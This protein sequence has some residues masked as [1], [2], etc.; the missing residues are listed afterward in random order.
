MVQIQRSSQEAALKQIRKMKKSIIR[1][2]RSAEPSV[3]EYREICYQE[4]EKKLDLLDFCKCKQVC[5]K[6]D[7]KQV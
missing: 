7:F 2:K 4:E 1:N 5:R 3:C 6:M